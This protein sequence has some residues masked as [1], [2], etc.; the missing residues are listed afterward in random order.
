MIN[1]QFGIPNN[2]NKITVLQLP[3][4]ESEKDEVM[5]V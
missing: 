5:L 2:W 1:F 3:E 4:A